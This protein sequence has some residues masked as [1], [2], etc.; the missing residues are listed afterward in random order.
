MQSIWNVVTLI[1]EYALG[2]IVLLVT[3]LC[4][5]VSFVVALFELP[6][7]LRLSSK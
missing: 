6:R 4:I 1:G 2:F 7:Y 5:L 3:L